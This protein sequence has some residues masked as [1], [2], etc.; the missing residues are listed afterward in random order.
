MIDPKVYIT[1]LVDFAFIDA[2]KSEYDIYLQ[3][4]LPLMAPHGTI[5]L[6]DVIK[7]STKMEKLY[8]F[9]EKMQ[10]KYS[11]LQLDEDDGV[12]IIEL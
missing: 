1:H 11:K 8:G 2:N 7:F 3:K 12:I 6:D 9:L 10:I 4:I 5:L